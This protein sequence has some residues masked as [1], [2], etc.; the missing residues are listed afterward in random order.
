MNTPSFDEFFR[1]APAAVNVEAVRRAWQ[2]LTPSYDVEQWRLPL[3]LWTQRPYHAHGAQAW[4]ALQ[5]HLADYQASAPMCI[6]LHVPFCSSKCN[7][8]DSYSF[9]LRSHK[10]ERMQQYIDV[11]CRELALWSRLGN[12]SRRPIS[13][14]HLGG[15]TPTYLGEAGLARLM[16][17][18]RELFQTAPTTEW[19]LES[20]VEALTPSMTAALHQL[21]FRRL[22]VG[23]QS[24]QEDVRLEIGR[25]R[26]P[27]EVLDCI[28][29]TLAMDWVVS[30]DLLCG[31]PYQTLAGYIEGIQSLLAASV[32]GFSLYELLIYPQN[33]RWADGHG[34]LQRSHLPNYWTFQAGAHLLQDAGFAKNLFN[35]WVNQRDTNIYFTFPTRGEDCLAVG[36]LADGVFGGCHYRHSGYAH[37]LK[38]V[39]DGLPGLDGS[40]QRTL[41]EDC[42]QP[43]VSAI[44]SGS[45]PADFTSLL[46]LPLADGV[47]PMQRWLDNAL[48]EPGDGGSLRLTAS[49]SW[50]AGNLVADANQSIRR[51]ISL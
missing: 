9:R 42:A 40:L 8:C 36:A 49:G 16:A 33:R 50:F 25:R 13:T 39:Q 23:V 21:G 45:L 34:L 27:A 44:L 26:S 31:L 24:L 1:Q 5:A 11:L 38:A 12:L 28:Q 18:C 14:V 30:V 47:S 22:H 46:G 3:P 51:Y 20:T 48:V 43:L 15:G 2:A 19:A 6:Y 7:F 29:R 32:D 35:H 37:Y 41:L 4:A 17:C 10:E